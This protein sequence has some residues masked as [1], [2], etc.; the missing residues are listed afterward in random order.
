MLNETRGKIQLSMKQL[1][2]FPLALKIIEMTISF[3]FYYLLFL[4][5]NTDYIP[6]IVVLYP[7]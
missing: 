4:I 1:Y 6:L 3:F 5:I 2:N 7:T